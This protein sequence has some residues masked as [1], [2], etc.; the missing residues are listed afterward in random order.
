MKRKY[1][2][3]WNINLTNL[4]GIFQVISVNLVS[5]FAGLFIKRLN[6]G[7][8]L[9]S[10]LNSL[11]AFFSIAAILIGTPLLC[12]VKN[13]KRAASA[14]FFTTRCFYFLMAFVPFLNDKY[15]AAAFVFLY[16]ALNFPGS[17][18]N[19]L[20]QSL[21]ADTFNPSIRGKVLSVR[22]MLS[23]FAGTITTLAAGFLLAKLSSTKTEAI[24]Y[25]QMF[26]LIAFFVGIFETAALLLQKEPKNSDFKEVVS[27]NAKFSTDFFKTMF[28]QKNYINFMICVVAFH[29]TW[30]MAWPVFLTYEVDYL[31]SNEMWSAII[32][33]ISGLG[34]TFG[35]YFWRKFTDKHGNSLGIAIAVL[36]MGTCPLLYNLTTH[37]R[38]VA[39]FTGLIGFSCAGILL[40]LLNTLYEVAP[41]ENR[42]TYIAFYN[43][44]TNITLVIAPWVGMQ[45]Y[46][47]LGIKTALFIIGILRLSTS[48]LFFKRHKSQ[49]NSI[50]ES[51]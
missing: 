20:W 38:Q 23:T 46:S 22:N 45:L 19:Y 39:Y 10:M 35:Y 1:N 31:H 14:A 15:R 6:A 5:S 26:F 30:Q 37:I 40:I 21:L 17:I 33:T 29:F 27:E 25:Y 13:K 36:G 3:N 48:L 4:N 44:S 47:M 34:T 12:S 49:N 43:L 7:D 8:N 18:A 41:R 9:V 24:H 32:S 16:G 2:D 42:T 11:P 51:M 28:K 50:A